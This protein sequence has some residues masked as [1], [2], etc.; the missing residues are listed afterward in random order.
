MKLARIGCGR[1]RRVIKYDYDILSLG[2]WDI[3]WDEEV[4]SFFYFLGVYDEFNLRCIGFKV[5][6][7]WLSE[8]CFSC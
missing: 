5:V 2:F 6:M 4:R 8:S 3:D 7:E 1:W